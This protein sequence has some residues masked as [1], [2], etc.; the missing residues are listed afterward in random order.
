[1]LKCGEIN[2]ETD[3]MNEKRQGKSNGLRRNSERSWFSGRAHLAAS[4][5][6]FPILFRS[7]RLFRG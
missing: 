4:K 3:E 6:L 7:F 1:M 5:H 2:H